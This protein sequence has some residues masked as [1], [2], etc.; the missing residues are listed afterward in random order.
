M[1]GAEARARLGLGAEEATAGA[2]VEHLRPPGREVQAHASEVA[3]EPAA[4]ARHEAA[5][6]RRRC[7]R[8]DGTPLGAPAR[9]AAVEDG[10]RIVA[11][12]PEGPPHSRGAHDA[13]RVVDD[14]PVA[15]ADTQGSDL[16][17]EF[18]GAREHVRE[19]RASIGD[20]VDVEE[21][22]AR[23]VGFGELGARV[24]VELRHVPGAVDHPDGSPR[25]V[26]GEPL[27][28]DEGRG[29]RRSGDRAHGTAF[30]R[31]GSSSRSVLMSLR[32]TSSAC[33]PPREQPT[34]TIS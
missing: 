15:R 6:R 8:L 23:D 32:M 5:R 19:G 18:R 1:S 21:D 3:D 24:A 7:A 34:T 20:R 14:H 13:A 28:R 11:E 25:Q 27:G 33:I 10:D 2:G 9:E 16:A 17:R 12:R 26:L 30:R 22:G 31:D 4:Q 29:Q